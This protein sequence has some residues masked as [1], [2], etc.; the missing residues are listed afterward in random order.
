MSVVVGERVRHVLQRALLR[1]DHDLGERE[2][3]ALAQLSGPVIELRNQISCRS[4]F[5]EP[6]IWRDS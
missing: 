6:I 3:D 1:D 5:N 4:V 2:G